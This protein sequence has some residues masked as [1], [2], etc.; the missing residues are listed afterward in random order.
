[1]ILLKEN[2]K[3]QV[4]NY[5]MVESLQPFKNTKTIQSPTR[6]G[7]YKISNSCRTVSVNEVYKCATKTEM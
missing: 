6:T 4:R 5:I 7:H 1:M 3:K 2:V